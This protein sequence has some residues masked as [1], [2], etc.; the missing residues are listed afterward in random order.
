MYFCRTSNILIKG[1]YKIPKANYK[2]LK[3][4]YE[5]HLQYLQQIHKRFQN[6][7][8]FLLKIKKTSIVN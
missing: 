3:F 1:G 5:S 8:E 2:Y 4:P 7:T 6:H